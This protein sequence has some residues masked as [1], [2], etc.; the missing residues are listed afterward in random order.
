MTISSV[1]PV[2]ATRVVS[3]LA[4]FYR[5]AFKLHTAFEADWY[6]HLTAGDGTGAGSGNLAIIVEGH[7]TM[8]KGHRS[9]AAPRLMNFE[10][11]DVDALY[12][13]MTARGAPILLELRDED[14]GQ[15][16]FIM[17]D[18]DGNLVDVIKLIPPSA[19]F[20]AQ[21]SSEAVPQ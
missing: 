7:E 9:V 14:F 19:E 6:V 12:D 11:D 20:A 21:Y 18:P 1:Y 4:A 3:Q 16:H 8:P 15:R 2:I 17:Q 13:A 5:D 10:T